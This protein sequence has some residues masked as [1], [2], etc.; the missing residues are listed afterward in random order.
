[1]PAKNELY[2]ATLWLGGITHVSNGSLMC[3][4]NENSLSYGSMA[5]ESWLLLGS[6]RSPASKGE[7]VNF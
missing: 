7:F 6:T 1:M 2:G 5:Y 3:R 4:K